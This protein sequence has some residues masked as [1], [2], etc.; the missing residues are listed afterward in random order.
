VS[1]D[2]LL[3]RESL[4]RY[5]DAIV[6]ASLGIRPGDALVVQGEPEHRPLL[7]AVAESAYRA[8]ARLVDVVTNDPLVLRA[9]LR[10]ASDEALGA[11]SPW[12]RR[13]L[14]ET[15]GPGGALAAITGQGEEGYLDGI[16]RAR[17][18]TDFERTAKAAAFAR[19]A[20]MDM[21]ARWTIA[22][23]PTDHWASRVYPDLAVLEAKRRLAFD[24]VHFCR[25]TDADG[26]GAQGWLRHVK[27]LARRAERLT[28]LALARVE[29]RGPGT[30]L[31]LG[32][33]PGTRWL[34]G[35]EETPA[36]QAL[37]PNMP[38]E[39]CF[40]SPDVR[41]AEGTFACTYPLSFRGRLV[42]GL[43]GEL[44]G[45]RLVRLEAASSADR[46]FVADYLDSD[47]DGR[48]LGELALVDE[49]SR[50]GRTGRTFFNTL[51]DENAASHIAFGS[52]FGPSRTTRPARHL[53]RS[54]THLDVMIGGPDLTVT[55]F[56]ANGRRIDLI[57]DGAWRI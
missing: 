29:L 42:E 51:L 17:I 19:R 49:T 56:D 37:A 35:R 8:G 5:A 4:D 30:D 38:T 50:I 18:A 11:V 26:R 21:R 7:V 48:R 22:A 14:R 2:E 15:S 3:P 32:L 9:R 57:R 12:L 46:D 10:Y 44:R 1:T 20:Q 31:V 28:R 25:L 33:V 41:A 40:T 52:G 34:G 54:A 16:P 13:R 55:G 45:G 39:E 27:T 23:W 47:S 36:G 43:R 24:L 6:K 53:N